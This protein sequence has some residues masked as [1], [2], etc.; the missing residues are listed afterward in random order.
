MA[1]VTQ[2]IPPA[3]N[4]NLNPGD[5][6]T[7]NVTDPNGC[8]ICFGSNPNFPTSGQTYSWTQGSHPF[9]MPGTSVKNQSL[10]YNAVSGIAQPCDPNKID[11][12]H[13]IHIG[14]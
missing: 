11:V 2:D 6:L 10:S 8:T 14:G 7:F 9:P 12:G 4:V 5:S 1:A 13:T 3:G